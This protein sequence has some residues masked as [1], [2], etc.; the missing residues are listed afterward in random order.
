MFVNSG[1]V[2]ASKRPLYLTAATVLASLAASGASAA[3][4]FSMSIVDDT[5]GVGQ[6]VV[7][8]LRLNGDAQNAVGAQFVV[9]Y[10]ANKLSLDES[11]SN[12]YAVNSDLD[13]EI[14]ES[15][16]ESS[17]VATY[18]LALGT[19]EGDSN[20]SISGD[21]ATLTFT[22][23]VEICNESG[24]VYYSSSSGFS[25]KLSRLDGN[26]DAEYVTL[27]AATDL[28]SFTRDTTVP[29]GFTSFPANRSFWADADGTNGVVIGAGSPNGAIVAPGATD[30]CDTAGQLAITYSRSAG[31]GLTDFAAGG[32]TTITWRA[33]DRC[34]NYIEQAQTVDVSGDSLAFVSC[35]QGGA[36]S[37]A[38]FTRGVTVAVSKSSDSDSDS[39]TVSLAGAGSGA[40]S[41]AEGSANFQLVGSVDWASGCALVR[42]PQ[43]T[44]RRAITIGTSATAGS[45]S[46]REYN[47]RFVVDASASSDYLVVGNGN[48]DTMIDILDFSTFVSQRGQSLSVNTT[49]GQTAKHTDFNASGVVDNADLSYLAVNFFQVDETCGGSY[50]G[51]APRERISV[52][53]L[54]RLGLGSQ[55]AA[56]V[57]GDGWVD[58]TDLALV[59]QG[60]N[61]SKPRPTATTDGSV[62]W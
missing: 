62:Q 50:D 48:A 46:S 59:L 15:H 40:S 35:A 26:G 49:A 9:K 51:A 23:L 13:M 55:A 22:P 8:K 14:Y 54:R 18:I 61:P 44:L 2:S 29:T 33:T 39:R 58:T 37:A 38:N 31:S 32:T 1:N 17:G 4:N 52:R 6:K 27:A 57:N 47:G 11:S 53:D 28:G 60:V 36:F 7:V 42:D 41:R 56:D 45:H 30:G 34:G 43:H 12:R 19:D 24:L 16:S 10:D 20:V 5:V 25:S 3:S 21:I